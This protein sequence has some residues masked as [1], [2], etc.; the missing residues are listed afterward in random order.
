[1][2]RRCDKKAAKRFCRKLLKGL[3]Y[4]PQMIITD[5]IN[6]YGVA[7]REMLPDVEH[8]HYRCLN[9]YAENSHRPMRQWG[10]CMQRFKAPAHAQRFLN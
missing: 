5:T 9:N 8:L 10:R 6:S 1:M 3:I 2:Q 7:Q 4:V